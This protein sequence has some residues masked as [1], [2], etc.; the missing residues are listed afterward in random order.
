MKKGILVILAVLLMAVGVFAQTEADFEIK[1]NAQGGITITKYTGTVKDV[2]IPST[3]EGIKVTEIGNQAFEGN[4]KI[5]SV[6][7][8]N[9]VT[10]IN[11]GETLGTGYYYGAFSNCSLTS[12]IIPNSV[13]AIGENAFYAC[14]SLSSITIPNSVTAI[15]KNAFYACTSLTSITIPASVTTIREKAFQFCS[16]L[17]SVTFAPTSKV[18]IGEYAFYGCKNLTSIIIPNSVDIGY[19]AFREC[20][21][22]TSITIGANKNYA[23]VFPNN[24]SSYYESQ[25]M[26]SGTYTWSGRLWSVK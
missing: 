21:S 8:P 16:N 26:K 20:T 4:K 13:T 12:V 25:G 9:G 17:A 24:F 23:W 7:I 22:L 14:T 1:Q 5:T 19:D 6:T 3:I 11:G 15:G 18:S 10:S 2:K